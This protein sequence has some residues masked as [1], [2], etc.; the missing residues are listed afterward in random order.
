MRTDGR[1]YE[2]REDTDKRESA[3][4]EEIRKEATA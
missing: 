3:G 2:K 4:I 1:K